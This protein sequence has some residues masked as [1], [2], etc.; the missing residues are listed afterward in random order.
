M[1]LQIFLKAGANLQ[2]R[3][4]HGETLLHLVAAQRWPQKRAGRWTLGESQQADMLQTFKALMER[5]LDPRAEDAKGRS[6]IDIAVAC[7]NTFLLKLFGPED[8]EAAKQVAVDT[9]EDEDDATD[10]NV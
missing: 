3:S 6:S 7:G 4:N 1:A 5:G 10:D 2:M 9:D 8:R